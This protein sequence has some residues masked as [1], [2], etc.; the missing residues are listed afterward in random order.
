MRGAELVERPAL[1][2]RKIAA[3]L[4]VLRPPVG[5]ARQRHVRRIGGEIEPVDGAAHHLLLPVIVEIRQQRGA[6]PAHRGM[7]IAVDP[8]RRHAGFLGLLF[9]GMPPFKCAAGCPEAQGLAGQPSHAGSPFVRAPPALTTK[10]RRNRC[11]YCRAASRRSSASMR[12]CCRSSSATGCWTTTM[13]SATT[14]CV[15]TTCGLPSLRPI[16]AGSTAGDLFR[17][18]PVLGHLRR[19]LVGAGLR[20]Q[21]HHIGERY[22]RR[23]LPRDILELPRG[24][25]ARQ[26]AVGIALNARAAARN[27]GEANRPDAVQVGGRRCRS[28]ADIAGGFDGHPF[29]EC[30]SATSPKLQVAGRVGHAG[31]GQLRCNGRCRLVG[32]TGSRGAEGHFTDKISGGGPVAAQGKLADTA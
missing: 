31:A 10:G 13:R 23:Q 32:R 17:D 11:I 15:L 6:R 18:Q 14:F 26:V 7:N 21:R 27:A 1:H 20:P 5:P 22:L 19:F 4:A 9:G 25:E 2:H 3:G 30:R 28:D 24:D 16:K 8:R 29:R 12:C